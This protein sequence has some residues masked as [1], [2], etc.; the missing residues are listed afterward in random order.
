MSLQNTK[1]T[2]YSLD[3]QIE[4]A[5]ESSD[6]LSIAQT[7]KSQNETGVPLYLDKA[8]AKAEHFKDFMQIAA[9]LY[10]MDGD[11]VTASLQKLNE[12]CIAKANDN[13]DEVLSH[14]ETPDID[15]L[16]Q[17]DF[18]ADAEILHELGQESMALKALRIAYYI[19][20]DN[21]FFDFVAMAHAIS[22]M[23]WIEESDAIAALL[24]ALRQSAS[25]CLKLNNEELFDFE[26]E[27][28]FGFFHLA[29]AGSQVL[30]LEWINIAED[31]YNRV[32]AR[33]KEGD[34]DLDGYLDRVLYGVIEFGSHPIF[35]S[36]CLEQ[37][38]WLLDQPADTDDLI[39]LA[40]CISS[41][42]DSDTEVE[43]FRYFVQKHRVFLEQNR[44]LLIVVRELQDSELRYH[45]L[46][47]IVQQST[48]AFELMQVIKMVHGKEGYQELF[49]MAL[50]LVEQQDNYLHAVFEEYAIEHNLPF[51]EFLNRLKQVVGEKGLSKEDG[52]LLLLRSCSLG[53]NEAIETLLQLGINPVFE[54]E[55]GLN[56]LIASLKDLNVKYQTGGDEVSRK[57]IFEF[58]ESGIDINKAIAVGRGA[59]TTALHEA[60]CDGYLD[61]VKL[62]LEKGAN[63]ELDE[64]KGQA[65]LLSAAY[66]SRSE[67]IK[68]LLAYGCDAS[69]IQET[70]A[71]W[72]FNK[73]K[74]EIETV[75]LLKEAG[76]SFQYPFDR[77]NLIRKNGP[78]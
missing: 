56:P 70:P 16:D 7:L 29:E 35:R 67:V 33:P 58:I 53:R 50:E 3:T 19:E 63:T 21:T 25:E 30:D 17:F 42:Q 23:E 41:F 6:Y 75:R 46:H 27:K 39:A 20:Q 59:K 71:F 65:L 37:Y 13:L 76:A 55:Q 1:M 24:S 61:I 57:F 5:S 77:I 51:E 64:D 72:H 26:G 48:D 4:N 10:N 9:F 68:Y 62:L 36:R 34:T 74:D 32:V 66:T 22:S 28:T 52:Q 60:A 45:L 14:P 8:F 43:A 44:H 38:K 18:L 78:G 69:G 54:D 73:Q 49:S 40:G 31:C 2:L 15:F 47:K 12:R 11:Y